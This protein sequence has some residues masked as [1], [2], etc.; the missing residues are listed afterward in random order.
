LPN[1]PVEPYY[2]AT[3]GFV[4]DLPASRPGSP[5]T[6]AEAEAT[7]RLGAELASSLG[8]TAMTFISAS[9]IV[10]HPTLGIELTVGSY[11]NY[12]IKRTLLSLNHAT[13]CF[14]D[15]NKWM[16][17]TA[18][19]TRSVLTGEFCLAKLIEGRPFAFIS[20]FSDALRCEEF[21]EYMGAITGLS[22]ETFSEGAITTVVAGNH[23]FAQYVKRE[24]TTPRD[25]S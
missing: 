14:V 15:G 20:A 7:T 12:M 11:Y 10:P 18:P 24:G 4:G 13:A 25:G 16:S 19:E 3:Y 1:S 2:G 9:R 17:P 6:P 8:G 22:I 21:V 5:M 23:S